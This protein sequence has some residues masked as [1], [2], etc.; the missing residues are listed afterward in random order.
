MHVA[1]CRMVRPVSEL[2]AE[3]ERPRF[4]ITVDRSGPAQHPAGRSKIATTDEESFLEAY[5]AI[6][7]FAGRYLIKRERHVVGKSWLARRNRLAVE[8]QAETGSPQR[9]PRYLALF[10]A[11]GPS[12]A[13]TQLHREQIAIGPLSL[14]ADAPIMDGTHFRNADACAQRCACRRQ[15]EDSD[16]RGRIGSQEGVTGAHIR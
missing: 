3:V 15:C 6:E 16:H 12:A 9:A 10:Q 8:G 4:P 5:V 11:N 7:A 13:I 14:H 2:V 1:T